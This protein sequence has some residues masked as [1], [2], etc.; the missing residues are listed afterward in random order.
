MALQRTMK[1]HGIVSRHF[2]REAV[3]MQTDVYLL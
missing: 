3:D 1:G 2:P